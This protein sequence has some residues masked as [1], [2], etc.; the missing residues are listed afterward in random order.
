LEAFNSFIGNDKFLHEITSELVSTYSQWRLKQGLAPET[1]NMDLRHAHVCLNYAFEMGYLSQRVDVL[2]LS[3]KNTARLS[4]LSPYHYN[5]LVS[6][7]DDEG[8]RRFWD[9]LVFSAVFPG[10]ALKLRWERTDLEGPAPVIH[11]SHRGKELV[12]PVL[13][14][15]LK[16]IEPVKEKG[17]IFSIKSTSIVFKHFR[18]T[19]TEARQGSMKIL[20]LKNSFEK[21]MESQNVHEPIL[22]MFSRHEVPMDKYIHH[23]LGEMATGYQ[24]DFTTPPPSGR[25]HWG[26]SL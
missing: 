13:P 2:K 4:V 23:Y 26:S 19:A 20:L 7:E 10:E 15:I 21:W 1:V 3:Q 12:I 14:Q 25:T 5:L 6:A 11:F 22:V 24:A 17:P 16:A 8:F 18:K 9:F